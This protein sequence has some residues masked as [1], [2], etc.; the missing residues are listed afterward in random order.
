MLA[1][2]AASNISPGLQMHYR[3]G[4]RIAWPGIV[5]IAL[6][7]GGVLALLA[8]LDLVPLPISLSTLSVEVLPA[9][10]A[11]QPAPLRPTPVERKPVLRPQ[12]APKPQTL[13]AA[14][15]APA[16]VALPVAKEAPTAPAAPAAAAAP[17]AVSQPRFDADYLRNPAPAYPALSRRMG[18]EGKVVLRVYVEPDGRPGQIEIKDSS[19]SS[20]L[21]QAAA[22]AVRRWQFVPA[23][24]AGETVGAWVLVPIVFNLKG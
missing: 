2:A 1:A 6:A 17:A 22:D 9:A 14:S 21:D 12:P 7:H 20:R 23:R 4:P 24:R 8:S 19:G 18:E 10:P 11:V 3:T 13:A 15:E 16:T 5:A